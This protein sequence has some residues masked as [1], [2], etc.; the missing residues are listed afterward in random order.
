[1]CIFKCVM[2]NLGQ[3]LWHS[4]HCNELRTQLRQG[5]TTLHSP[6]LVKT[7]ERKFYALDISA[8]ID[9]FS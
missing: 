1:M 3:G 2:L 7:N 4:L 8:Y 5:S 9:L 6:L